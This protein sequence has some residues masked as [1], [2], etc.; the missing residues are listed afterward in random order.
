MKLRKRSESPAAPPQRDPPRCAGCLGR[1]VSG[2]RALLPSRP[3]IAGGQAHRAEHL[4]DLL[5]LLV[6]VSEGSF[7][8]WDKGRGEK[9][10]G[11]GAGHLTAAWLQAVEQRLIERASTCRIS[12]L[13]TTRITYYRLTSRGRAWLVALE[14]SGR[15]AGRRAPTG[16]PEP[17]PARLSTA[18]PRR[19]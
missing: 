5:A 9:L 19:S 14:G 10:G 4:T 2:L 3:A 8:T 15:P 6:A 18:F 17:A 12:A 1:V 11:T 16:S 7:F 13:T